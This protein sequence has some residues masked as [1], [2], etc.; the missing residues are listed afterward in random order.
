M[1]IPECV[2]RLGT[3]CDYDPKV[4]FVKNQAIPELTLNALVASRQAVCIYRP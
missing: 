1:Q 2:F 3:Q 4:V